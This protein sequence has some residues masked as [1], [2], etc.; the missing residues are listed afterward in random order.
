MYLRDL[1][2]VDPWQEMDQIRREMNRLFSRALAEP[3]EYPAVNIWTNQEAAIIT[4]E[5]PGYDAKDINLSVVGDVLNISGKRAKEE[6]KEGEQYLREERI[7]G[8]FER[9]IRLPFIVDNDEVEARFKNGILQ[10]NL[11]RVESDKPRK[12]H[13]KPN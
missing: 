12:I 7:A 10:V 3:R 5:L 4:A 2:T 8:S 11:P 13:I 1:M 6:L 9:S